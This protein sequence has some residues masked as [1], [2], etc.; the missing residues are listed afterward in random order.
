MSHIAWDTSNVKDMERMFKGSVSV[1]VPNQS[2]LSCWCVEQVQFNDEFDLYSYISLPPWG[3]PC[4]DSGDTVSSDSCS[5]FT[6]EQGCPCGCQD[7]ADCYGTS[8]TYWNNQGH[9]YDELMNDYEC[10]CACE[11]IDSGEIETHLSIETGETI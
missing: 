5:G 4:S 3:I 11:S 6:Q 7:A 10:A 1:P 2:D 9:S 8:C